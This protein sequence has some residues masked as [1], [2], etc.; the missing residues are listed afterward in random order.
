[1]GNMSFSCN[2][3]QVVLRKKTWKPYCRRCYQRAFPFCDYCKNPIHEKQEKIG[4]FHK[5]PCYSLETQKCC[6]CFSNINRDKGDGIYCEKC[7]TTKNAPPL[8]VYVRCKDSEF[9]LHSRDETVIDAL[10]EL[11]EGLISAIQKTMNQQSVN[12]DASD[13]AEERPQGYVNMTMSY[14]TNSVWG[15]T[16]NVGNTV[17]GTTSFV[18]RNVDKSVRGTTGFVAR[19]VMGA[20]SFVARNVD[21]SVRGTTG[22]VDNSVRGV[23]SFVA[24]NVDK[25]VRG[26]TGFVARGV[27]RS[28]RGVSRLVVRNLLFRE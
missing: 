20:T 1:M 14:V 18:A 10:K 17:I 26:T 25:S 22:F 24:R 7:Y 21:K 16:R 19:N 4:N 9:R 5:Y 2:T 27:H 12:D 28:V 15:V 8:E 23:T 13:E 11:G 6:E 3:C